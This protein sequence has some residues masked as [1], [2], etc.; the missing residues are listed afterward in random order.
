[1]T[2]R[3]HARLC[4]VAEAAALFTVSLA[5]LRK[6]LYHPAVRPHLTRTYRR[7]W[8]HPRRLRVLTQADLECLARYLIAHSVTLRPLRSPARVKRKLRRH[9]QT[10]RKSR[11]VTR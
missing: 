7:A 5:V 1:V 3:A 8:A 2:R 10:M 6:T 11:A 4:Y 9:S